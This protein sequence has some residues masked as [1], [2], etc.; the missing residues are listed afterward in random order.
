MLYG[1]YVPSSNSNN[2][3]DDN[4]TET[5]LCLAGFCTLGMVSA[6]TFY[7]IVSRVCDK[8]GRKM[9]ELS[10]VFVTT[11][12]YSITAYTCRVFPGETYGDQQVPD[13]DFELHV[14][15]IYSDICEVIAVCHLSRASSLQVM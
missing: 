2:L 1:R 3:E 10:F 13:A 14:Y 15:S 5:V 6:L 11:T 9:H 8:R 12:I 4:V 7:G